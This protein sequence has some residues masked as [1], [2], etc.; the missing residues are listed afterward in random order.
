MLKN[1]LIDLLTQMEITCLR[2]VILQVTYKVNN[3]VIQQQDSK[4]SEKN[5]KISDEKLFNIFKA[6]LDE[7][8]FKFFMDGIVG[9]MVHLIEQKCQD[10]HEFYHGKVRLRG[11]YHGE[12]YQ[13]IEGLSTCFGP[14]WW[15]KKLEQ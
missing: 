9:F 5:S 13:F 14:F 11:K 7:H 8:N 12:K 4:Q 3:L 15:I 1:I 6:K 2:I 10:L